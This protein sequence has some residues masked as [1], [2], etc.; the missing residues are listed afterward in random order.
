[1]EKQGLLKSIS[2]NVGSCLGCPNSNE[3][4]GIKVQITGR[5]RHC[6][7]SSGLDHKDVK[8]Y[9]SGKETVFDGQPDEGM[10]DGLVGCYKVDLD[11]EVIGG[12]VTWLGSGVFKPS[13]SRISFELTGGS[14][15]RCSL[16]DMAFQNHVVQLHL[17]KCINCPEL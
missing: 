14:V 12:S 3:E 13:Q 8:D 5:G 11:N 1:M 16:K 2:F 15:F 17:C 7:T 6:E 4:G 9:A 10:S